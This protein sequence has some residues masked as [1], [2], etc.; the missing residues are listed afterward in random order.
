M[1]FQHPETSQSIEKEHP[2]KCG[3]EERHAGK[4]EKQSRGRRRAAEIKTIEEERTIADHTNDIESMV[5][6][7]IADESDSAEL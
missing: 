2:Q 7:P 4:A 1:L 3:T 6:N 5:V